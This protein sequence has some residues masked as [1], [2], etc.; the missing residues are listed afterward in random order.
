MDRKIVAK[1][2][3]RL[4]KLERPVMVRN[5]GGTNNNGETII[6]QVKVN[7]YYKSYVER[8]RM[9]MCNLGRIDIILGI[10]QLQAYNPEINWEI[11]EV[12]ITRYPPL[13]RRNTKLEERQKVKKGKRVVMLKEEK[14]VKWTIDDKEDQEREKKV[15]AD[16]HKWPLIDL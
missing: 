15:K 5:I 16:Y 13:C 12:K 2:R 10:L 9:N 11:G 7:V 1:H 14:I 3:F 8:M 6:Y 4:Q